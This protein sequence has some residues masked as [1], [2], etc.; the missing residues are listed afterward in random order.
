MPA[1]A[2]AENATIIVAGPPLDAASSS[3]A[4]PLAGIALLRGLDPAARR[5][6]ARR[7]S[8]RRLERGTLAIARGEPG[9]AVLFLLEGRLSVIESG[10]TGREVA[11]G[12]IR[13]GG[14]VGE[15][16][17]I[18]GGPRSAD[19]VAA[20]ACRVASLPAAA[21]RALLIEQP[22]LALA[23]LG[24][25][26]GMVREADRRITELGTMSAM[27]RLCRELLRQARR[28]AGDGPPVVQPLPTQEALARTTGTAR[29]TVG[30]SLAQLAHAGLVRRQGRTLVLLDAPEL[31]RLAGLRDGTMHL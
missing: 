28:R 19:V 15:L 26:A 12:E 11:Y 30:R 7:C 10:L 21:F 31:A 3:G 22:Q 13:P 6:L 16:A 25:V 4:D 29:E 9:D 20:T 14:H 18:D 1:S 17:A 2:L 27:A 24:H 23:L 8:W 5:A